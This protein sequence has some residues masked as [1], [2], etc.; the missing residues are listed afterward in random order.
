MPEPT[1]NPFSLGKITATSG[2]PASIM[3]NRSTYTEYRCNRLEIQALFTNT[4][5][6]RVYIGN[7]TMDISTMAG[8]LRILDPGEAWVLQNNTGGCN[9]NPWE[10][11]IDVDNNDEG[12]IANAFS[13]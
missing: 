12:A 9:I 6:K 11:Y 13:N 2:T 1:T 10:I 5:S 8:V 3:T 7:S 4:S